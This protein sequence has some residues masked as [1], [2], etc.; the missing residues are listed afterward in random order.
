MEKILQ[1][2]CAAVDG[3]DGGDEWSYTN[4]SLTLSV[5]LRHKAIIVRMRVD[6]IKSIVS[7]VMLYSPRGM[8]SL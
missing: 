4:N 6:E 8:K 3:G 7:I 5:H 2:A 1:R